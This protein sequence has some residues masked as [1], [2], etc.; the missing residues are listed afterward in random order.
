MREAFLS[1]DE[2]KNVQVVDH[3]VGQLSLSHETL[4]LLQPTSATK[5]KQI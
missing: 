1:S 4:T 3:L 2:A 5:Q